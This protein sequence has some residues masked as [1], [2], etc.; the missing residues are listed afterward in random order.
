MRFPTWLAGLLLVVA[1]GTGWWLL[2]GVD[3]QPEAG[4]EACSDD[5]LPATMVPVVEDILDGGPY[6]YPGHD[7]GRFGN[8]EGILP[9]E[10]LGYYREFTVET[11]G[12]DHRG[13]RRIVTGGAQETGPEVWYFT[14]DHYEGFCQFAP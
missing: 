5:E 9:D 11:P 4:I 1:L 14:D 6:D 10:Q 3:T 8:Y 7:A 2:G 13:A 12:L